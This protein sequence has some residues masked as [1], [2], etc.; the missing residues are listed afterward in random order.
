MEQCV[1]CCRCDVVPTSLIFRS[2][3]KRDHSNFYKV[4]PKWVFQGDSFLGHGTHSVFV[5]VYM[6]TFET[7][8]NSQDEDIFQGNSMEPEALRVRVKQRVWVGLMRALTEQ[9]T[10]KVLEMRIG[11]RATPLSIMAPWKILWDLGDTTCE[12][13]LVPPADS[14]KMVMWL[15]LPLK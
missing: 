6:V 8:S 9:T 2:S 7:F 5:K 13:T 10:S 15:G 14:P 1:D 4:L 11:G 3:S 12:D